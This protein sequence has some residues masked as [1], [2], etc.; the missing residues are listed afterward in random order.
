MKKKNQANKLIFR[1]REIKEYLNFGDRS[2]GKYDW[3]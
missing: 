2:G 3:L 1:R